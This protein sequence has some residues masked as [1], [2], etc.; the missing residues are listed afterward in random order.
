MKIQPLSL[1]KQNQ[2]NPNFKQGVHFRVFDKT[3]G[4]TYHG[5]ESL[6]DLIIKKGAQRDDFAPLREFVDYVA[7]IG[8]KNFQKKLSNTFTSEDLYVTQIIKSGK[9]DL[10]ELEILDR[11]IRPFSF[12]LENLSKSIQCGGKGK[13]TE[14]MNLLG[15]N[16]K[17][18]NKVRKSSNEE[19]CP[20]RSLKRSL[21]N[22][23]KIIDVPLLETHIKILKSLF[24]KSI[25]DIN[26]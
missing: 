24:K 8:P 21:K 4:T 16:Q 2:S 11:F 18:V 17:L 25:Y 6:V 15:F 26:Y 20:P 22:T 7:N 13:V 12:A 14:F 19:I 3:T 10:G 1:K 5:F 23:E 9:G